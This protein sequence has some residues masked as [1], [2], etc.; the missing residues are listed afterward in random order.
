MQY[1]K[2]RKI[3]A[4]IGVTLIL[5][6]TAGGTS[7]FNAVVPFLLEGMQVDLTTFMIGPT[8]ATILSF[9]VSAIGIKIIDIIT[10]KWCMLI[11]TV[12]CAC[13]M[14]MIGIAT[15]FPLWI[16][17]NI[18]N[19]IVLAFATYA[20]AGGVLAVFWG[21]NTQKAFGIVGG[22]A[23]LLISGWL[24][25]SS[26]LLAVIPYPQLFTF[27][28]IAILVIGVICNLVLIG[29]TPRHIVKSGEEAPTAK[30][31]NSG[32]TFA[33]TLKKGASIYCF[34]IAMFLVA[35]CASG[36]TSYSSVYFTSFGMMATTA[37]L[38]LS[39]YTFTSAIL[40]LASGF[41]IKKLGVR[42]T[43]FL[44]YLGFAAGIACMLVW[45]FTQIFPLAIIGIV[46]CAFISYSTMIP[47]LFIPDL[48]GMKDYTGINAAGL[49][50][51]YLGAVVV[52]FGLSLVIKA[53]GYFNSFLV[54]GIAAVVAL[55]F[56]L[57]AVKS[58]PMKA[59]KDKSDK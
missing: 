2:G 28:A 43:S 46:L 56:M 55:L 50:G 52:L 31:V 3:S 54:L 19:G 15:S 20:A 42:K 17:A 37:A 5:A 41:I 6:T 58:S 51:Y 16:I 21:E 18:L 36:I 1:S 45:S 38:M 14:Y 39:I 30:G 44:I 8:V 7:V 34:L 48:F 57:V 11:G 53:L 9:A 25:L 23:A 10:P 13:T 33:E 47:G 12:C 49:A 27:Y 22:L 40:K 4:T 26:A 59:L 35:W 29:K 32:F 24:A